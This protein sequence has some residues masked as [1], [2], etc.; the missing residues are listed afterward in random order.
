M[1]SYDENKRKSNLQKHGVDFAECYKIFD[2]LM[3]SKEDLSETYGEQ[4]MQ[5]LGLLDS[6]LI[7]LIWANNDD[8]IRIISA[9]K[10]SKYEKRYYYSNISY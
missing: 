7:F 9:R 10:A 3:I 6:Q 8:C 2:H 5:S 4:R 1:I